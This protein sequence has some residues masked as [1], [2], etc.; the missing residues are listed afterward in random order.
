[1][2]GLKLKTYSD[3]Y[4]K[5]TLLNNMS[6]LQEIDDMVFALILDYW[7]TAISSKYMD[8]SL[9]LSIYEK[10]HERKKVYEN[11]ENSMSL[12]R[13]EIRKLDRNKYQS[14]V[15]LYAILSQYQEL[16]TS[17]SGSYRSFSQYKQEYKSNFSRS[18]SLAKIEW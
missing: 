1:V 8:I 5:N 16:V 17:I 3:N 2:W 7:N 10:E 13:A 11:L 4:K 18:L 15:E 12:I 14:T 9:A 6:A